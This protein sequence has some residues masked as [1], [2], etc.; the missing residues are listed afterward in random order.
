MNIFA[1]KCFKNPIEIITAFDC[2]T[3]K[4][5]LFKIEK[6][7]K[8]HYLLGYIR[9]EA[10][11]IFSKKTVIPFVGGAIAALS[12]S[13]FVKS[14]T[15]RKVAV[16]SMAKGMKAK[17]DAMAAFETI[18]EDAKDLCYEAKTKKDEEN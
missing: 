11:D 7:S 5:A 12:G 10:K 3:F 2:D 6:L 15:A 9:Y 17:D 16:T 14:D 8:T 13:K 1:D 18:K 4:N